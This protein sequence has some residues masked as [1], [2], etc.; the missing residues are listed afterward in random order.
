MSAF[1]TGERI[2]WQ[3]TDAATQRGTIRVLEDR[4]GVQ[5][6]GEHD[7]LY[8]DAEQLHRIIPVEDGVYSGISDTDY[9]ADHTSLSSSGARALLPPSSPEI[10]AF[11]RLKPPN[12]KP[13]YDFGH[14]AHKYV[15]GE[16]SDIVEVPFDNWRGKEAQAAREEAWA[17][18]Q[19]PLLTK[20]VQKAEAMADAALKHSIVR[21][22]LEGDGQPELSGYW[23]DPETGVRLRFRTDWLGELGGRIVGVDYKTTTNAHPTHCGKACGEYGYN[24]QQAWYEDGLIATEITDDPD[25]WLI[26]QSKT[27]PFPVSVGRISPHHVDL[28]RRRNRQAIQLYH[29]CIEADIW[30]GY[31]ERMHIFELPS[32]S[33]YR[34]EQ[35]LSA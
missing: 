29:E 28:G 6:D 13:E 21:A 25:F 16:G 35:E 30:P 10:F 15:L 7:L 33:V 4:P 12:P 18:N 23:H 27:P 19:V 9:H 20:D 26:F 24:M 2:W 34:Q 1:R 32:Y 8:L 31:G 14:G 5:P 3:I 17:A 22:L 11:E